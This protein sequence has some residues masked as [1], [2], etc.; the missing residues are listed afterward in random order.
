LCFCLK[1]EKRVVDAGNGTRW[2]KSAPEMV[3]AWIEIQD[4]NI[5]RAYGTLSSL[6][7]R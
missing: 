1:F 6:G 2:K 4:Y 3:V 5:G 7:N